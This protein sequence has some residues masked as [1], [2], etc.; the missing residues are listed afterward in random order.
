MTALTMAGVKR[1][2]AARRALR[3]VKM[4]R[5]TQAKTILSRYDDFHQGDVK[6]REGKRVFSRAHKR[7]KAYSSAGRADV[8]LE[9]VA[10]D[11][12][13]AANFGV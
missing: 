5:G 3:T 9:K 2:E 11:W 6:N 4:I 13:Q 1:E 7:L 8:D 12:F 10:T